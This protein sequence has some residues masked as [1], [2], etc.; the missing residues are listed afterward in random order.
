[1]PRV[2]RTILILAFVAAVLGALA[3]R[4]VLEGRSALATGDDLMASG[5]TAEAI[6]A[7]ETAA[8]WYLPLAPHVDQAYAKLRAIAETGDAPSDPALQLAAWRA[9]RGAA[10]AT[11][12]L[13]TPHA[14]DL[15]AANAA[16]ASISAGVPQAATADPAWHAQRL[17]RETRPSVGAAALASTGI[18]LWIFGAIW[19]VRRGVDP[20]GRL[21]RRAAAAGGAVIV[22]GVVCWAAGLYNA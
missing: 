9:I 8:R 5:R 16:I 20:A 17:A 18:L 10:M 3:I 22:V 1:M 13:V 12:W 14:D 15:A 4:V 2:K 11:R 7:Y 19:L 6:R 21:V